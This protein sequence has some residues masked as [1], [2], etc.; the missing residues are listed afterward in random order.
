MRNVDKRTPRLQPLLSYI[1]KFSSDHIRSRCVIDNRRGRDEIDH[2][3]HLF[4][5]CH[6]GNHGH[7]FVHAG[8]GHI[9]RI[10][11]CTAFVDNSLAGQQAPGADNH[12]GHRTGSEF[13][14]PAGSLVDDA[15]VFVDRVAGMNRAYYPEVGEGVLASSP[16]SQE[17]EVP[18]LEALAAFP[19]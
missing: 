9:G 17:R 1:F 4:V 19:C 18:I 2:D 3:T 14:R 5:H 13:G 8:R 6:H 10:G 7:L 15:E 16:P 12:H 11:R